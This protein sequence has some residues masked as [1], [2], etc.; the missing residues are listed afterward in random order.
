MPSLEWRKQ[1][2]SLYSP[3]YLLPEIGIYRRTDGPVNRKTS[4]LSFVLYPPSSSSSFHSHLLSLPSRSIASLAVPIHWL[5]KDFLKQSHINPSSR[6][7]NLF[8]PSQRQRKLEFI[9]RSLY[10]LHTHSTLQPTGNQFNV[11]LWCQIFIKRPFY[12][13]I[14]LCRVFSMNNWGELSKALN[15][16]VLYTIVSL[17]INSKST[18][19]NSPN[20]LWAWI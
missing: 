7:R 13:P 2:P 4:H 16:Y 15:K 20:S 11:S 8:C 14:D 9:R 10:F 6:R 19:P 17:L 12:C 5:W 18:N 1:Q 3:E